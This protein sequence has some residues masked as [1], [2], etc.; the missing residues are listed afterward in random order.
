MSPSVLRSLCFLLFNAFRFLGSTIKNHQ[1]WHHIRVGAEE[2]FAVEVD[3]VF[4][5]VGDP[6]FGFP[7]DVGD[8]RL[9][10]AAVFE[11]GDEDQACLAWTSGRLHGW[12]GK[13]NW[14]ADAGLPFVVIREIR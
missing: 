3:H 13:G 14:I 4:R 11:C 6:Y 8:E 1:S 9:H 10:G 12:R 7:G 2:A 5:V